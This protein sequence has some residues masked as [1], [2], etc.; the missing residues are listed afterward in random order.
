[1]KQDLTT[2]LNN[3]Q[4]KKM[5][6]VYDEMF[7]EKELIIT[8][9]LY[10][11]VCKAKANFLKSATGKKFAALLTQQNKIKKQIAEMEEK[12][13]LDTNGS[14]NGDDKTACYA[15]GYRSKAQNTPEVIQAMNK[16]DEKEDQMKKVRRD[17]RMKLWAIDGT[18]AEIETL[19]KEALANL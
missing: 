15:E 1:M 6:E 2:K 4:R 17:V 11:N 12:Y 13:P 9:K 16:Q 19:V 3:V 8:N 10:E 14:Y 18:F 5:E 7:K